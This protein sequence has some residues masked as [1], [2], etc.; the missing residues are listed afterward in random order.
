[1]ADNDHKLRER[2]Y[3]AT[4]LFP[5]VLQGMGQTS[6]T[7]KDLVRPPLPPDTSWLTQRERMQ[8]KEQNDVP[9]A[10][11]LITDPAIRST[12][13]KTL[14]QNDY[15]IESAE[16]VAEALARL[17][18]ETYEVVALHS[19]FENC[20]EVTEMAVHRLI[21]RLP[22][23][24]R[25]TLFYILLDH[26]VQTLYNLETLVFSANLVINDNEIKYLPVIFK[27]GFQDYL[28][29]FGPLLQLIKGR[30]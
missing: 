12:V 22:M 4:A 21:I 17:T 30:Q 25:R 8:K 7:P 20:R 23:A 18:A 10:L 9:T 28:E 6:T 26:R 16:T 24:K 29:V 27:K 11:V 15:R 13:E 14:G 5:N 1:M 3:D 19:S 2:R